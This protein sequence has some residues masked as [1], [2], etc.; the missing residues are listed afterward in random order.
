MAILKEDIKLLASERLTDFYD[1]GGAMTGNEVISGEL[2]N[3]FPD[4]SR[5]DRTYGRV[6]MRKCFPAVLTENSDMYYG[7]HAI[8]TNPPDDDNVFVTMFSRND[9]DDTRDDARNRIESYVT[10]GGQTLLRPMYDQLEGQRSIV[11]FQT[12]GNPLPE[13]GKTIVLYK[14]TTA[15]YQYVR[16]TKVSSVRTTFENTNQTFSVDVVTMELS[17]ALEQTFPGI[18]PTPY[19]TL[20]DTKIHDTFVSDAAKYYGVSKVTEAISQGDFNIQADSIYNQLV[21]TSQIESP[22]VDQIM[23]G[24]SYTMYP[25]GDAGS[26]T[27]SGSRNQDIPNVHLPDGIMPGS[28]TLVVGGYEFIDENGKLKATSSDGGY[29]G[30]VDYPSGQI[31]IEKTSWSSTVTVTAT[32]AVAVVES[33]MSTQIEVTFETRS[34]NYTPNLSA[35]LPQPGSVTIHYMAQGKWYK[36]FDDGRGV[37]IS[38]LDNVGTGTVDYA[39]GSCIITLGALPDVGTNIIISWGVGILVTDRS[40]SVVGNDATVSHQLPNGNIDPGSVVITWDDS[41][42]AMTMTDDGSGGFTGDGTGEINYGTGLVTFSPSP[43]PASGTVFTFD[44]DV[45]SGSAGRSYGEN[46]ATYSGANGENANFTLP[47]A[48]ILPGSVGITW[49]TTYETKEDYLQR[50]TTRT[51]NYSVRDDSTGGLI[52][53]NGLLIGSVDYTTGAVSFVAMH[54]FTYTKETATVRTSV[55]GFPHYYR[56]VSTTELRYQDEPSVFSCYYTTTDAASLTSNQDTE[57][58][59]EFTI[60]VTNK[61]DDNNIVPNSLVFSMSGRTYYDINGDIYYNKDSSTG[62]GTF[63]GT[64]NYETGE[65][66]LSVF[67]GVSSMSV[68]VDSLLTKAYGADIS[69]FVFRTPGSP[70]RDGSFSCRYNIIDGTLYSAQSD[71]SGIIS[72]TMIEGTIDTSIGYVSI[73]FGEMVVAAGNESEDWYDASLVDGSGNIWKPEFGIPETCLYNAV[74]YSTL[75]LS[76]D[77]VGIEP[78]RLPTDGRVPI[79]KSG[80]VCVLHHNDTEPIGTSFTDSQVIT[81]SRDRL[82]IVDLYTYENVLV[83]ESFYTVDLQAGTITIVNSASLNALT[84]SGTENIVANHRIED[85]LLLSEAQINGYLTSVGPITHDYPST[86]AQ[87]STA[88]IFGDLAGRIIRLFHQKTW[89]GIWR[90]YL[91]GDDTAAKY[92]TLNY[93]FILKNKGS[94]DQ[95]WCIK[96]TSSTTVQI[97]GETLGVIGEYNIANEI[98]PINPATSSPYFTILNTGWGSGWA[99]GNNIRFDTTAANYP[100]WLARTTMQGEVVEP[101]DNFIIQ[102]RGDAN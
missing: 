41:G 7:S 85:M 34:Y 81:L 98:A 55:Y 23:G 37:F 5:L 15:D 24:D 43:I 68:T 72:D 1:G 4:I 66:S 60:R 14:T 22:V 25:K 54:P 73:K 71:S 47:D 67:D 42:T 91:Y 86:G 46:G 96:F 92:D 76:A 90:D 40:G 95:R 100:V 12:V 79:F 52:D 16:I 21:P 69:G 78:I 93:P 61:E 88:L 44:H 53:P 59:P 63:A 39:S 2:N 50:S 31:T 36:L 56:N 33:Y 29:E 26:L 45:E 82:S 94:A 6:S 19:T 65:V 80:D 70:V 75:P 89:D 102:I 83:D 27:F 13:A 62:I 77:L 32:P 74:M 17:A 58:A 3:L 28:L 51:A 11:C 35:P 49:S 38:D 64:I 8:I 97:I 84:E 9:F 87:I 99:T 18:D 20:A 30:T 101:T 10:I 48:P 57:T